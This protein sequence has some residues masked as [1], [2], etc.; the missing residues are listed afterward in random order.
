M[1]TTNVANPRDAASLILYRRRANRLELLLG[2]RPG[3]SSF[4]PDVYVF[5]GGGVERQD[6]SMVLGGTLDERIVSRIAVG[7]SPRKATQLVVAAIRE[8]FEETG[9]MIAPPMTELPPN[10]STIPQFAASGLYPE[11]GLFSYVGRAITPR[12]QPKRFHARFFACDST[13][14]PN[15]DEQILKGNGELLDLEWINTRKLDDLPMRSVTQFM[16]GE[17]IRLDRT[18]TS[19]WIGSAV[20]THRNGKLLIRH[21]HGD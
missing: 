15:F 2:R 7:G 17:F 19:D 4:M 10:H 3:H 8:T 14:V 13:R 9:L 18:G 21:D 12:T 6:A 1:T 20:Y 11:A 16:I 5:P